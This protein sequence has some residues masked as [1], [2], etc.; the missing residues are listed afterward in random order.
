MS[1]S[2]KQEP[3]Y[4][5]LE[6]IPEDEVQGLDTEADPFAAPPP[7][8]EGVH[9]MRVSFLDPTKPFIRKEVEGR[10]SHIAIPLK[11]KVEDE[12]YSKGR[13]CF[14]RSITTK[15]NQ[16]GASK[17]AGIIRALGERPERGHKGQAEQLMR[18]IGPD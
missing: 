17:V 11:G 12:G 4:V 9:V 8:E 7:P 2:E 14:D 5:S 6:D 13:V 15:P 16:S 3:K 18:L 1:D 10:F